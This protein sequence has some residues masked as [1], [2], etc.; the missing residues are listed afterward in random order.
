MK[1]EKNLGHSSISSDGEVEVEV[2]TLDSYEFEDV[3]IIKIDVELYEP[4]VLMGAQQTIRR[5][6][7]LI[8]IED[9]T[10]TYGGLLAGYKLCQQWSELHQ[11][12]LY[13]PIGGYRY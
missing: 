5:C 12:Y 7:P 2:R 13:E 6:R 9:W 11:T 1:L 4:M 3:T 10:G 8:C